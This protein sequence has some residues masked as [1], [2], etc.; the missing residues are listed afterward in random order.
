LETTTV[1]TKRRSTALIAPFLALALVAAAC[2]DDGD[3]ANPSGTGSPATTS[4]VGSSTT[5]P[6]SGNIRIDG[7][8][9][10]GPLAEVAAELYMQKNRGVRVTVAMS[11]TSG[12][13]QKFCIGENDMNNASRAIK[14][15]EVELCKQNGIAY[16][17]IQV[18]NDALALLV[19]KDN[20]VECLTVAQAN[21]IWDQ[22]STV[23]RWGDVD[24]LDL[25]AGMADQRL[26][27]YG[28]GT[29]SGTFDFFT[30]AVN[31]EEG[32]IRTDF[33]DIGEDDNLAITAVEGDRGALGYVPY[34]FFQAL[35][36][37][38]KALAID[39]GDGCVDA[40]LHN[41]Q[42]N[43]YTPLGRPLFVYASDTALEQEKTVEFFEFYVNHAVRIA[44]LSDFIPMT[45]AQIRENLATIEELAS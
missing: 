2:G 37:A 8:S 5:P 42:N 6:L 14:E 25:P 23:R 24:G 10:V 31:G 18:A 39:D 44:E 26:T 34:S 7:S 16:E 11:G 22:D 27:L 45:D 20:P 15:S 17:G 40:T 13:F 3:S 1:R 9:T 36:D 12:G 38:V 21:Q 41:V 19:N 35:G 32:R 4:V 33:V 30:E 43:T 29:D 28:P